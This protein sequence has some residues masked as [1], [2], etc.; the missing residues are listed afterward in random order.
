MRHSRRMEILGLFGIVFLFQHCAHT[1][2]EKQLDRKV[3][4]ETQVRTTQALEKE[5]GLLVEN[6]P[7]LTPVQRQKLLNLRDGT[8]TQMDRLQEDSLKLRAILIKDILSPQYNEN[9]VDL[10]K[11]RIRSVEKK[12]L[13]L[14]INK[15][16]KANEILGREA[17]SH[18]PVVR[19]MLRGE[20]RA[21]KFE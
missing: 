20:D 3:A 7:G 8:R 13:S 2:V 9:E 18:S 21:S 10:V 6:A 4:A 14:I 5:T 1:E 12:R 11:N 16:E 17:E 19:N 15:I